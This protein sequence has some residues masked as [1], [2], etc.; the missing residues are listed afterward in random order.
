MLDSL[1]DIDHSLFLALNGA[2]AE[3][4]DPVMV[5]C[6]G[7][8]TWIPFYLL[9]LY[10]VYRAYGWKRLLWFVLGVTLAILLADQL[11]VHLF[12][13]TVQRLRPSHNPLL[14]DL[15]YLPTGHRGGLYG[16]VSSHAAN[17]FAVTMVG[18]LLTRHAAIVWL[19]WIWAVVVSY[20]RI[21]M[22]VHF[23]G[24]VICGAIFGVLIG[25]VVA[26]A[27]QHL[28]RLTSHREWEHL[29]T[30]Y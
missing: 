22:G 12:K 23:P 16:F 30:E 7:K 8:L 10:L 3:W 15:V 28:Y 21:Y 26:L 13:N 11:S 27:I 5:F 14:A 17:C 18:T 6:S 1:V 2:H 4:L 25:V 20:S 24:D 9:I 19:L 29:H